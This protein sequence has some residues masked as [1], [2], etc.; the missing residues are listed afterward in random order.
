[1]DTCVGTAKVFQGGF[2]LGKQLLMWQRKGQSLTSYWGG[3]TPFRGGCQAQ[4]EQL[5]ELCEE[6]GF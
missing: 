4:T 2:D 1:M 6:C 5:H 3:T